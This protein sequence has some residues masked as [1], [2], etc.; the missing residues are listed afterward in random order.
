MVSPNQQKI[1]T[2]VA[3]VRQ[4]VLAHNTILSIAQRTNY[5]CNIYPNSGL[6]IGLPQAPNNGQQ[7]AQWDHQQ[8]PSKSSIQA[9]QWASLAHLSHP[10]TNPTLTQISFSI[11]H[12]QVQKKQSFQLGFNLLVDNQAHL[13]FGNHKE[14]VFIC[15]TF[16]FALYLCVLK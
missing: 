5:G 4:L 15:P 9:Y 7:A 2:S 3:H 12:C 8:S 14:A 11:G 13:I 1:C 16:L 6:E 10:T